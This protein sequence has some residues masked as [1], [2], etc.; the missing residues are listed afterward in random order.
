[1]TLLL[2]LFPRLLRLSS[3]F[4][5]TPFRPSSSVLFLGAL[6]LPLVI[7]CGVQPIQNASRS[8][9]ALHVG[10]KVHGGQ[11]P[12]AGSSIQLYTAGT[13][14][15]GSAATALLAQPVL[16][17][18]AGNFSITSTYTCP[19]GELVYISAL[20]GDPGI[21]A[22]NPNLALMATI[23]TCDSL[24][25]AT[26][27]SINELTTVAAAEALAPYLATPLQLGASAQ[28][29]PSL[30]WDFQ[31]SAELVDSSSGTIVAGNGSSTQLL[32]TL[33]DI[34]A[35]CVN[36]S[37][38]HAGDNTPCGQFFTN[39]I[40]QGQQAPTDTI[41][42]LV[43]LVANPNAN[44]AN[45]FNISP[46][47]SPFQPAYAS[48]PGSFRSAL[49]SFPNAGVQL[50]ANALTFATPI[51]TPAAST[52]TLTNTGSVALSVTGQNLLGSGASAFSASNTC[53]FSLMPGSSCTL[54]VTIIPVDTASYTAD[55]AIGLSSSLYPVYLPLQ[56]QG[57]VASNS[58]TVLYD[59]TFTTLPQGVFSNSPAWTVDPSTSAGLL[60][61]ASG[62][63]MQ[64][65]FSLPFA[66]AVEH[67]ITR[68]VLRP[69]VPQ[70][71][72]GIGYVGLPGENAPY[73]CLYG[74]DA[75]SNLLIIGNAWD[76]TNDPGTYRNTPLTF[77]IVVGQP[78]ILTIDLGPR[79]MTLTLLD[80]SSGLTT[81]ISAGATASDPGSTPAF[82][83]QQDV[84]S[85]IAAQGQFRVDRASILVDQPKTHNLFLG[86]SITYGYKVLDAQAWARQA[87]N[88]NSS[89]APSL[90]SGRSG[91]TTIGVLSRL[92]TEVN[93][94]HPDNVV[95]LIG[96]ND[97]YTLSFAQYQAN[98]TQIVAQI[99]AAGEKVALGILP[100]NNYTS[101]STLTMWNNFLLS[102]PA[103]A[104]IRFDLALTVNH[105]GVTLD[106]NLFISDQI[107]PNPAGHTLMYQQ[108]LNDA[109]WLFQ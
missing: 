74:I 12:V 24:N 101:A 22:N 95:L 42:A 27:V 61:P 50:S 108:L 51:G 97:F 14:A 99:H 90:I 67:R 53:A 100:P 40:Q 87:T 57:L 71:I 107:H 47:V 66:N 17:D 65:N 31:L 59:S 41:S 78:Y 79:V 68:L 86:D 10:G 84:L 103:D 102:L 44:V 75:A 30:A 20:G 1:M 21:G 13:E 4:A 3:S 7:G 26:N 56:S 105:D 32:N 83:W 54:N 39:T 38:G 16:S 92:Q 36:S 28:H 49:P 34:V 9:S 85:F 69:L 106:P 63:N 70:T 11:Q 98:M 58:Q 6:V 80:P 88:N 93:L 104:F 89:S 19:A 76:G 55:L 96:T 62:Q 18:S 25:A 33:A 109:P 91:A 29:L 48:A 94:L 45:L 64:A 23:G 37:G 8:A 2:S 72:I 77:P 35:A 15:D 5:S 82:G 46:P 52:V 43:A 60:S 81:T 73:G